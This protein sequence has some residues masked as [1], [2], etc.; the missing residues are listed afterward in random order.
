MS[1]LTDAV[2]KT[3]LPLLIS[4]KNGELSCLVLKCWIKGPGEDSGEK[5]AKG[6]KTC[7]SI[8]GFSTSCLFTSPEVNWWRLG[9]G[10]W[11]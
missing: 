4:T 6:G 7:V 11:T 10:E 3:D 2:K 8:S 9:G 1:F 5:R